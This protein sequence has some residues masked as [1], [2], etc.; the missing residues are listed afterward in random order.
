M[1]TAESVAPSLSR[2]KKY[3][4]LAIRSKELRLHG[5]ADMLI[6]TE[7]SVYPLEFKM[8]ANKKDAATYCNW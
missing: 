5:I 2:R 4:Q 6:E 7:Q 8:N 1:A 3:Y